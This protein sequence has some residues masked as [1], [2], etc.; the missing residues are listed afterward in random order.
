VLEL[1]L[2]LFSEDDEDATLKTQRYTA[3]FQLEPLFTSLFNVQHLQISVANH[4]ELDV[5]ALIFARLSA[6]PTSPPFFFDR[7]K[8]LSL[9]MDSTGDDDAL[10]VFRPLLERAASLEFLSIKVKY[11][12]GDD[13][14]GSLLHCL[15]CQL[16][17]LVVGGIDD[18]LQDVLRDGLRGQTRL[19]VLVWDSLCMHSH[20][21]VRIVHCSSSVSC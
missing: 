13:K 3:A 10:W 4:R 9:A 7:V 11:N 2:D 1:R 15:K 5:L 17:T 16:H 21:L 6:L 8:S 20:Q 14:L 12:H 18:I 19:Q